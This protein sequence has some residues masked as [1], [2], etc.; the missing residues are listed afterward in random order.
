MA[1]FAYASGTHLVS[2][3]IA[4]ARIVKSGRFSQL[5]LAPR[6]WAGSD[7]VFMM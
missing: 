2:I 7:T 6:N 1:C 3:E 5:Q 4:G